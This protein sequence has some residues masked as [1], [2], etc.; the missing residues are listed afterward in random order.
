[1]FLFRVFGV[2]V[3]KLSWIKDSLSS[4][5]FCGEYPAI[6]YPSFCIVLHFFHCADFAAFY[7]SHNIVNPFSFVNF[8]FCFFK[9]F[10][11]AFQFFFSK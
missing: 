3:V 10:N 4:S 9:D 1:M 6:F 7:I 11:L 5:L 8:C 2:F